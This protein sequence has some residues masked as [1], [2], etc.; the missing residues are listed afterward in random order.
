MPNH[1]KWSHPWTVHTSR[2][3]IS[4]NSLKK[5][6]KTFSWCLDAGKLKT[7]QKRIVLWCLHSPPYL[8][9]VLSLT[10]PNFLTGPIRPQTSLPPPRPC[11]RKTLLI[12]IL[13]ICDHL[14]KEK[15]TKTTPRFLSLKTSLMRWSTTLMQFNSGSARN[16]DEKTSSSDLSWF[17]FK[18]LW[19]I[20]V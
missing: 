5:F 17:S 10:R 14:E 3:L 9:S 2:L 19:T 7:E 13:V 4:K 12:Y 15:L 18:A 8:F 11:L 20:Q 16:L 1:D 6:M